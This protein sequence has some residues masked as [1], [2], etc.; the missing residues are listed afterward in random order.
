[1]PWSRFLHVRGG[2][3]REGTS[4]RTCNPHAP[5]HEPPATQTWPRR[6][7]RAV[8]MTSHGNSSTPCGER[9]PS[10]NDAA[11]AVCDA[12]CG[13]DLNDLNERAGTHSSG[14][15]EPSEAA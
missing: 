3:N 4:L 15:I 12:V 14:Y 1:M 10:H 6:S 7:R 8:V 9:G 11:K 5:S 2:L 13:L